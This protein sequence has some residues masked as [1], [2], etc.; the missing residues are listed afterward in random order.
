MGES[1]T[2]EIRRE[3]RVRPP[4]HPGEVLRQEWLEPLDM[5][6]SELAKAL[7]V[8]RQNIYEITNGK[9][10]VS[11]EMAVRLGRWSRMRPSFWTGLQSRYDLEMVEWKEGARIE[12]EVQPLP[13]KL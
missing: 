10:G 12:I 5:N 7:S 6:P 13:A 3:E 9:R 1:W 8:N 11:P 2:E 4:V